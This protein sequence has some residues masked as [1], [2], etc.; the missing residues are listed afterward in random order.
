MRVSQQ[1]GFRSREGGRVV[2]TE[3][4]QLSRQSRQEGGAHRGGRDGTVGPW[5]AE[6]PHAQAE[7]CGRGGT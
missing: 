4:L 2:L 5:V 3:R 7:L 1:E 6:P